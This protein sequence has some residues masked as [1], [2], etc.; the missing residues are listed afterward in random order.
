MSADDSV[1]DVPVETLSEKTRLVHY[2]R[3]VNQIF[4]CVALTIF[5]GK[6]LSLFP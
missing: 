1:E 3:H 6:L 5:L 4:G 2:Q